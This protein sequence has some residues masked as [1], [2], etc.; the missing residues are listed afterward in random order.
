MSLNV[1]AHNLLAVNAE[2]MIGI[3]SAQK[4]KTAEKLSSGYRINRAAD[5]AAGLA[6]SEGMRRMIRGLNQ[7]TA[8]AK[9]GI[10]WVKIG[11]GS[12]NEAHDILHRM[13]E[14]TVKSL[15]ETYTDDDRALMQVEFE[16]LQSEI[17]RLTDATRF[18][19][20]HIFADH[21]FPYYQLD[22]NKLW[23]QDEKHVVRDGANN[24]I[25]DYQIDDDSP[26]EH[27]EITVAAGEYTTQELVDEIDTALEEA[28]LK[29]KGLVLEYT[30]TGY[31]NMNLEGG[32]SLEGVSGGLEYLIHDMYEGGSAGSLIGTTIFSNDTSTIS[33]YQ[34]IND[35]L[36]FDIVSLDGTTQTLNLTGANAIPAGSYTRAEL[37]KY[38]NENTILKDTSVKAVEYGQSIKLESDDSI[39]TR[40]K[41][42]M[43]KV[44]YAEKGE[45]VATSIFYDNIG[46][47]EATPYAAYLKGGAVLT[48]DNT[49]LYHQ[50]YHIDSSNNELIVQPNES[51]APITL[52]IADGDYT[53][54]QMSAALNQLFKDNG[55]DSELKANYF[56]EA[57]KYQGLEITSLKEGVGSKVGIDSKSSAYK[58]L[59]VTRAYNQLEI[60]ETYTRETTADRTAYF[61]GGKDFSPLVDGGIK[62][63][64]LTGCGC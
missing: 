52:T 35:E 18:N 3:N 64:P 37:I 48:V 16:H 38:L 4:A 41:G 33:I 31:C 59:F 2:R 28:G 56:L 43:F 30:R 25:I 36:T 8:N 57:G 27:A 54:A 34:N 15:N 32:I 22:G 45:K 7:G 17:D 9:D 46:Y 24:L 14:L 29:D 47:S 62:N 12:L 6:I 39:I 61:M 50:Y 53:A 63:L 42:N 23:Q 5:D 13:T 44:D 19:E 60:K 49:D 55:L 1:V 21:E 58:T 51:A 11:D 20:K 40:L 26:V 10:S